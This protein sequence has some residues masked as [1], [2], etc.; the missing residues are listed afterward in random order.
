MA[1]NRILVIAAALVALV[2]LSVVLVTTDVI[3]GKDDPKTTTTTRQRGVIDSTD[4]G[5]GKASSTA[6]PPHPGALNGLEE[7][8][9]GVHARPALIVKIDNAPKARPQFGLGSADIVVEEGV[10][11]GITRLAVMFHS[12]DAPLVGPVRSAR[13]TDLHL[14][15]PLGRP[16]FAYS[17]TNSNFQALIDRSPLIDVGVSHRP[18]AYH[19]DKNRPAPYNLFSTTQLLFANPPAGA[20]APKKLIDIGGPTAAATGAPVTKVDIHWVDKVRTDVTW[21]WDGTAWNRV[22]GDGKSAPTPT[23]DA[24]GPGVHPR[25]IV[26]L[27]VNYEDTGERDQS[28]SVVPEAKLT[29]SGEAWIMRDG[30]LIRGTWTKP[31]QDAPIALADARGA[32]IALLPGQTWIELPKPGD[33]TVA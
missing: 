22:Q 13:S 15:V 14:G 12:Q 19:R 20:A 29:G 9:A 11:G 1:R 6:L 10:E 25:N 17:G 24:N 2:A 8:D 32:R 3:G 30:T 31:A 28:N 33:A 5:D 16:L 18:S 26:V 27:F 4:A 21:T 23:V 7:A